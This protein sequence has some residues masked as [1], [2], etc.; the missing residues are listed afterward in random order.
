M[1][2]I[3][4]FCLRFRWLVLV[5]ALALTLVGILAVIHAPYDVFP[6]FGQPTITVVTNA[7]GLAP[8]QIEALVTTPVEDAVNGIP[9]LAALR[10]QS[11]EGLSVVTAVFRGSTNVYLD[12]Q[13][14]SQRLAPLT[15]SLPPGAVPVIAPLQ[16]STGVALSIGLEAPKLSLMQL[17][18]IAR[19]TIRPALLAVPGVAKVVI[20]GA[21]PEQLQVQF[22]PNKLIGLHAGLNELTTAA[23]A[24]SSVR[25]AGVVN[26]PNQQIF[27][28]SHGQTVTPAALAG[29]LFLRRAHRSITLGEVAQIAEAPPPPIGGALVGTRPG[30]LLVVG[31][32]YG[33][34]TLAVTDGLEHV[35][36]TLAPA[37]KRDGITVLPDGLRPA[38]FIDAALHD[39]RNSL[40]IGAFLIVLVLYFALRNWRTAMISFIAIPLSLLSAALILDRLGFSLN[41]L[42]L[43]G[44]AIAIGE[45]VDDAV[46]GVENIYRRLRESQAL[47]RPRPALEVILR[48]TLEVRKAVVFATVAVVIVFLPVLHL[49]GVAGR[50]FRPLALA[51]IFAI[52]CSLVVALTVT[53]ALALL[54]LGRGGFDPADPPL[55][56]RI[57]QGYGR[58][59]AAVESHPRRLLALIAVL[60]IGGLASVPMLRSSFLPKFNENDLIVH[61]QTTPGTALA[62][63]M[64]IGERAIAIMQR[65]PEVAHVVMH[66]GRAH[67]SNGD[68]MTNKAE[69]DIGLTAKGNADSAA[70]KR[71]ILAAVEGAPGVRWWANTFLTERIH[72]T[73]SG[74]TAPVVATIYGRHLKALNEDARRVAVALR[75]VPGA[76]GVRV[77]AP[78]GTPELSIRLNRAALTRYGFTSAEVLRAIQTSYGGRTVGRVYTAGRSFPIVVVL[79]PSLR[80]DPAA[81]GSVPLVNRNGTVVR[82]KTL[83]RLHQRSGQSLILHRGAQRV[84]VVTANVSGSASQFVAMA[85]QR[86]A[87]LPLAP[88]DYIRLGGTASASG[89]ARL[90][91]FF[92]FGLALAAILCL[93]I[94]A[95]RDGRTVALLAFNLPFALVGGIAAIWIAGLPVSLGA[96]VGF[97]TVFGITLRNAIMLLS[98]YRTLVLEERRPWSRETAHMGAMHRLAPILMTASVTALGLLPLAIG[99]HL[100]G[101]EI[102]GPMAI[103]ILGGLLSSTALTLL[104]LPML[105]LRFA[106]FEATDIADNAE[107]P[108]PADREV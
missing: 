47:E 90:Q 27:L 99:A 60:V 2:P 81:I 34:N 52:S 43:G 7:V 16:S 88:G 48:A 92:D 17:T 64:H 105:A 36:A 9:G 87:K 96:A 108:E 89:Q 42:S 104:V 79:P 40:T 56:S 35:L 62:T 71:K 21:H 38:S 80:A 63:T 54:L 13:L 100:P 45:V 95:L 72:E 31:T 83:A 37:L 97:V 94:I 65:L 28:M 6:E 53:P 15:A 55:I 67:L 10:S 11:M 77:Q 59:L 12:Q 30:L 98:H 46:V 101:Q 76:A 66:A 70:A 57:K 78:P 50:F 58:L 23:A 68:A 18:E 33:A 84:Q 3:I 103:V 24:A 44:L 25:G 8:R 102:E 86:L 22:D 1:R 69:I 14:V 39:V 91:L 49:T 26:T 5:G 20:F 93:L 41:T 74:V 61:F 73:L 106:R 82:L 75:E 29:S 19:W 51:Y 4:A 107:L 85:R 32:Q